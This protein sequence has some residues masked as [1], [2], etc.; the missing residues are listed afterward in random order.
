MGQNVGG[1]ASPSEPAGGSVHDVFSVLSKCSTDLSI[2]A[3]HPGVRSLKRV[4]P[5]TGLPSGKPLVFT[6]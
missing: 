5:H 6:Q 1:L 3:V 4:F 2:P